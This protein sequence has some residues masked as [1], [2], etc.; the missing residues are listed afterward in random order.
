MSEPALRLPLVLILVL[1]GLVVS[2][3][4]ALRNPNMGV[5]S[6]RHLVPLHNLAEGRG[7]TFDGKTELFM[8]PGYGAAAYALHFLLGDIE[9]SGMGVSILAY[10]LLIPVMGA[11][12]REVSAAPAA[13]PLGALFTA[14]CPALVACSYVAL[15]DALFTLCMATSFLVAWRALREPERIGRD[16]LLGAAL[17]VSYL[18]RPEAFL[19]AALAVIV[20]ALRGARPGDRRS[21]A[22]AAAAAAAFALLAAP[23]LAF[24]HRHIGM[25]TVSP[26]FALNLIL[27][28][29]VTEGA[30]H[31]DAQS[32]LHPE[33]FEPGYRVSLLEYVRAQGGKF[34]VRVARNLE[35]EAGHLVSITQHALA[36]TLAACLLIPAMAGAAGLR[37]ALAGALRGRALLPWLPF[38]APLAALPVFIIAGRYVLPYGVL[39]LAPLAGVCG[40]GLQALQAAGGAGHLRAGGLVLAAAC[41]VSLAGVLP[42]ARQRASLVE[43]LRSRHAHAG[44]RAAGLWIHAQA[45]PAAADAPPVVIAP[46]KGQVAQF[47]ANGGKAH[48]GVA[49]RMPPDATLQQVAELVRSGQADYLVLESHYIGARP[50]LAP[51][52]NDPA[53]AAGL[54][55]ELLAR[56]PSGLYQIYGRARRRA[57]GRP[58]G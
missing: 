4:L 52:W 2:G 57:D 9:R 11:V 55:L 7:Y 8:P 18:V 3:A 19:V 14:L 40:R 41:A 10:L 36:A 47:Y 32:A 44:L 54:G 12:S 22:G 35:A 38:L 45:S 1:A 6:L 20:L 58:T 23:Y 42:P 37:Q 26:K 21:L 51:L 24:V 53:T 31:L 46:V 15:S 30:D 43:T 27:G 16:A 48:G 50:Q 25:W 28:E 33:Q 56:D 29:A 34:A 49:R 39:L 17:G 13:A 5:D